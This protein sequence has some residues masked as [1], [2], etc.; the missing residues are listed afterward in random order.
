MCIAVGK[1]LTRRRQAVPLVER[2]NGSRWSIQTTPGIPNHK[3]AELGAVACPG[4]NACVAVGYQP[5]RGPLAERW[6]GSRWSIQAIPTPSRTSE[7]DGVSCTSAK[8]CTTVG[9]YD[10]RSAGVALTLAERWNGSRW[11]IQ[12]TPNPKRAS[13]G[14]SLSDVSCPSPTT[15]TAIGGYTTGQR[16]LFL[17]EHW[18]NN[19][20]GIRFDPASRHPY[21]TD[22]NLRSSV[23]DGRPGSPSLQATP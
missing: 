10:N 8:T 19:H 7:L 9:V 18:T 23:P 20:Q 13:Q 5:R 4:W 22:R 16:N 1:Y 2:W 6:N 21:P 17:A 3:G 15:C 12:H 14:S 11:Y